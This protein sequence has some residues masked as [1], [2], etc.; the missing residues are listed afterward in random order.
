M[1]SLSPEMTLSEWIDIWLVSYK[2]GT[3]K[4]KS[5]HQFELLKNKMPPELL[6][7]PLNSILPIHIQSFVNEFSKT[8]SKSYMDKMR[9]FINALFLDAMDNG[10]LERNPTGRIKYPRFSEVPREAFT[11]DEVKRIV[12]YA[13]E[14]PY[15]R[16]AVAII[17]LLFTGL[18]RGELLG[19]KWS[20]I[21]QDI[22]VVNRAVY[23]ENGVPC[24]KENQAKTAKSLRSVPLLPEVAFIVSELPRECE[25]IF[26]TSNGKL[27]S[28][29]NFSRDYDRFFKHLREAEPSVRYLSPHSCRHTFATLSL[30]SGSDIRVVQELLGHSDIKTTS[31]YTH[32]D[33]ETM[34]NAVIGLKN[35][36]K[37]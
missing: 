33:I 36:L 19:L 8:V 24:V 22:L 4:E 18:R 28:P 20:D 25:Y 15:R 7:L 32:P 10:L 30:S 12:D 31:R 29:R 3:I 35:T 17:L 27:L 23:E 1:Q 2:R 11:A 14:Y 34:K 13:M 16:I 26:C 5:F 9:V 21:K 6:S 37:F